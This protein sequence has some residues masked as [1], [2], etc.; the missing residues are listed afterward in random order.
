[1]NIHCESLT[2]ERPSRIARASCAALLGLA[3]VLGVAAATPGIAA[4]RRNHRVKNNFAGNGRV[5]P[6]ASPNVTSCPNPIT[7]CGCTISSGGLYT[8]GNALTQTVSGDCIDVTGS[9]VSIDMAGF[10]ITASGAGARNGTGIFFET[11]SSQGIL[12]GGNGTISGFA[13][14]VEVSGSEITGENFNM[15]GNALSGL[16]L[17]SA[18]NASFAN[19]FATGSPFGAELACTNCSVSFI[20]ATGNSS[21]GVVVDG[22]TNASVSSFDANGNTKIGVYVIDSVNTTVF[23]GVAGAVTAQQYGIY[24]DFENTNVQIFDNSASG[25]S[26]DDALD[27]GNFGAGCGSLWFGNTFGTTSPASC[28]H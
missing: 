4:A 26:V 24:A 28:I 12:E 2:A 25:N 18:S 5:S 21:Y 14:G 7:A 15:K 9:T 20:E 6:V 13:D 19:M 17:S 10:D 16:Y 27:N 22:S 3:M 11:G 23:N 1:M 8:L